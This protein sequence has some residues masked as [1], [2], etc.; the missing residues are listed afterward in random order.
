VSR[1]YTVFVRWSQLLSLCLWVGILV[2]AQDPSAALKEAM[3]HGDYQKA[4]EI[5]RAYLKQNPNSAEALSNLAVVLARRQKYDEAIAAY[6]KALKL[7]PKLTQIYFNL[8]VA[9]LGAQKY[10]EAVPALRQFLK[11]YPDEV[12]AQQLL[13]ICLVEM[14]DRTGGIAQL[15]KVLAAKPGDVSVLFALAGSHIRAGNEARGQSLLM[16]MEKTGSRPE[17]VRLLQGLL[18]YR[19]QDY[20]RAEEEFRKAL[21]YDPNSAAALAAL[22]RV[23]LFASDDAG[24]MECLEKA[25]KLAPQDAESSYQLGVLLNRNGQPTRG[26]ELL[27][28]AIELR[29]DYPDPLYALAKIEIGEGNT[30]AALPLL[31]RA[32]SYAPDVEAVRILLA[33]TYQSLGQQDKAK[34]E[35]AEVRRLQDARIGKIVKQFQGERPALP[36]EPDETPAGR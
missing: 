4:E 34:V 11:S 20:V 36:M 10:S 24:A 21:I 5:Y 7:N 30:K 28:K 27:N 9:Y 8:A 6:Q 31:E 18:F 12:R 22:G 2:G 15:E 35:F 14:G 33:R 32:V 29:P 3:E 23:R 1:A 13:G 25:V 16:Q 17:Q 26:R 19:A